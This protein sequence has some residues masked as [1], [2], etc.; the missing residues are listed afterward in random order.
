MS[1]YRSLVNA[2]I[3]QKHGSD[4][5]WKEKSGKSFGRNAG[6][7]HDSVTWN[8]QSGIRGLNIYYLS[9]KHLIFK[10]QT[11]A[12]CSFTKCNLCFYVWNLLNIL[13]KHHTSGSLWLCERGQ[14][15]QRE[16]AVDWRC[17]EEVSIDDK[18]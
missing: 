14:E 12:L 9:F 5:S 16:F 17:W 11:F 1:S 7:S 6:W 4:A 13:C 3:D 8:L 10:I 18:T 2:G 15:R